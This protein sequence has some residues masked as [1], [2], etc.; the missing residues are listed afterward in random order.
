MTDLVAPLA[1]IAALLLALTL[2]VAAFVVRRYALTRALGTFD[3]SLRRN[4]GHSAGGWMLGVARYEDDRLDW[5]RIFSMSPRPGR[6]MARSRLVVL[7]RRDPTVA[8][9]DVVMPD[10]VIVRCSYGS[11]TLELAMSEQA[12]NGLTTWLESAPPGV[13]AFTA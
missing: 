6:S 5:Y 10:S 8:E 1:V 13:S 4:A 3:C 11:T 2:I 7:D 9:G 12:Y